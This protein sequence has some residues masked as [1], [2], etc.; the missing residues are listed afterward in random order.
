[1]PLHI[2]IVISSHLG[3]E[4]D[5]DEDMAGVSDPMAAPGDATWATAADPP[6]EAATAPPP[7]T[8]DASAEDPGP[9]STSGDD[10]GTDPAV[11]IAT[12]RSVHAHHRES[13]FLRPAMVENSNGNIFEK[14]CNILLKKS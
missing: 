3:F 8:G 7:P 14:K 10:G 12:R 6:G 4:L 13:L 9:P 11:A 2:G 1:M 5:E